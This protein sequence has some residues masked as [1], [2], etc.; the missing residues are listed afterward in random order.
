M[1]FAL[2][3]R[4][5]TT[6]SPRRSDATVGALL[7]NT[8]AVA[9]TLIAASTARAA[10]CFGFMMFLRSGLR[11]GVVR[12]L[13]QRPPRPAQTEAERDEP[14]RHREDADIEGGDPVLE[15]VD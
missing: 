1:S 3:I 15:I 9:A 6:L 14:D 7:R 13:R 8:Q 11:R 4:E 2:A 5:G 10:R 12:L